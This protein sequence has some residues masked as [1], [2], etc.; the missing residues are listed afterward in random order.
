MI[1]RKIKNSRTSSKVSKLLIGTTLAL[2]LFAQVPILTSAN[3]DN[4]K[5]YINDELFPYKNKSVIKND[6]TYIP[7]RE[8]TESLGAHVWWNGDSSTVGISKNGTDVSFIVGSSLARVNGNQV[9][10]DRSFIIDGV[11]RVPLR[12][13]SETL[14]MDVS[15]DHKT[16]S[17]FIYE[18]GT[19]TRNIPQ[20][21]TYVS[22]PDSTTVSYKKHTVQS[23]DNIWNLGIKYGVPMN[24]LLELNNLTSTS[25][26]SIGQTV[27]I[28]VRNIPVQERKSEKHGE[29]LDWWT[30]AQYMFSI[31]KI[32][33]VTD[34]ETGI[35]FQ[36]KRTIGANHADCEPLTAKDTE[37]AKKIWGGFNWNVRP[38][39]VEIDG[40]KI[41]ASMSFMPH[42]V[43]YI[44][45]NNFEGHFDIHFKN[46]TRHKDGLIDGNHQTKIKIAA[47]LN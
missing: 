17:V 8:I 11:T 2:S 6:R 24:E 20:A 9:K 13:L 12:F 26:L 42:D 35:S 34:F 1:L 44:T 46:S 36:V 40:R 23:G 5:V 32:G 25:P 16:R 22:A 43:Q 4:I 3:T 7:V 30:E 19:I 29:Y 10:M 38:V 37:I 18:D 31:G 47:G 33:T 28:P 27:L 41:A 45:N 15:W 39:I 21:A 14:G